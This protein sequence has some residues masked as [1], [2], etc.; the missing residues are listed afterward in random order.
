LRPSEKRKAKW[1]ARNGGREQTELDALM[2]LRPGE[3]E[4]LLHVAIR[5]FFDETLDRWFDEANALPK[6]ADAWFKALPEYTAAVEAIAP[7]RKTATVAAEELTEAVKQHVA[8]VRT[9][10]HEAEDAPKLDPLAIKPEIT[11][12]AAEPM[13]RT[14]DDFV[15]ATRKLIAAGTA[16]KVVLTATTTT[17]TARRPHERRQ[18]RLLVSH[19]SGNAVGTRRELLQRRGGVLRAVRHAR[20][21]ALSSRQELPGDSGLPRKGRDERLRWRH[22]HWVTDPTA[23]ARKGPGPWLPHVR[24]C[25]VPIA[26]NHPRDCGKPWRP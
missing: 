3:L 16:A 8:A 22:A 4:D 10:V 23:V 9:A 6:G 15:T 5:P 13:F 18:M 25:V 19:R 2:A 11:V 1:Q 21:I 26:M 24:S 7:L 20:D 14:L 12:D 17:R